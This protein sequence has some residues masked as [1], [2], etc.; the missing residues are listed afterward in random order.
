[1]AATDLSSQTLKLGEKRISKPPDID[2]SL[3]GL[4]SLLDL[5]RRKL[6]SPEKGTWEPLWTPHHPKLELKT[7][8]GE[9]PRHTTRSPRFSSGVWVPKAQAYGPLVPQGSWEASLGGRK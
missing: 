8:S 7:A 3:L 5:H 6:G 4:K 9:G 1:M 2:L